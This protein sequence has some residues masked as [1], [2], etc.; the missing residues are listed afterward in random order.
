M[1]ASVEANAREGPEDLIY[2]CGVGVLPPG[3]VPPEPVLPPPVFEP[4]PPIPVP[5]PPI[6]VEMPAAGWLPL[7]PELPLIVFRSLI[8]SYTNSHSL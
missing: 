5:L 2:G 1:D 7:G 8:G 4:L 6:P 3:L